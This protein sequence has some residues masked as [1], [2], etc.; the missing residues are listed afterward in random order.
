[1]NT[2]KKTLALLSALTIGTVGLTAC[3]DDADSG[4]SKKD[5][6]SNASSATDTSS[7]APA[8]TDTTPKEED[9][10]AGK[11]GAKLTVVGWDTADGP[12]MIAAW[13]GGWD[14]IENKF[15]GDG[16]IDPIDYIKKYSNVEFVSV[17]SGSGEA[18]AKYDA[19]FAAGD[20]TDV[21]FCENAFVLKY[22]DSEQA[23]PLADIGLSTAN[24]P[25]RYEYTDQLGLSADGVLKGLTWQAAPGGLVYRK[26]LA[27]TYLNVT[28]PEQMQEKVKDWDTFKA[29]AAEVYT[30]SGDNKTALVSSLGNLW[31]AY[32]VTR[33]KSWT[34]DGK[35]QIS[36]N[37]ESFIDYAKEMRSNGYISD[38]EQWTD[39]WI[40][41]GQTDKV[42][43]YFVSTWGFGG[44]M[45]DA[46][47]GAK[48]AEKPEG[49][50]NFGKWQLTKGPNNFFWGG[51]WLAVNK[52]TDNGVEAQKF[53]YAIC[54]DEETMLRYA[55]TKGE[56][57]N[58]NKVMA[59][60]VLPDSNVARQNLGGQDYFKV[61]NDA[62]KDISLVSVSPDDGTIKDQFIDAVNK[63]V[64]G[65]LASKDA[66]IAAFRE[67][68]KGKVPTLDTS[69]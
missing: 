42:M 9:V 55:N 2:F 40:A 31:E 18:A 14:M 68:V 3:G 22:M 52:D 65:S 24:F 36:D 57:M 8:D 13:Q 5:S 54:G 27:E 34:A 11:G 61:L 10:T 46:A 50:K 60:A 7:E 25:N 26:D 4:S 44:F 15:T 62:A 23:L 17:N 48:T 37:L 30:A 49:G 19:R 12:Y 38:A 45:L 35:L 47:G 6:S 39:P 43:S 64:G 58:N 63:Y 59:E 29:T 28:S 32:S 69:A 66:T 20:D 53:L 1:M 51:T 56:F 33:E 67:A 41:I 16:S 21:F